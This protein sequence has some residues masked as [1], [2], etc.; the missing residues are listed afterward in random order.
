MKISDVLIDALEY[1]KK[2][3]GQ[4]FV[5][6]FGG[7]VLSNKT[8]MDTV[9]QDL[10]LLSYVGIHP[11]VLHGGGSEIDS[12]MKKFGKIPKK[13]SGLRVTDKETMDI[14]EMV[15]VGKMNTT[16]VSYIN[17]HGGNAV[18]LSGKSGNLFVA[19]KKKSKI[20][21]GHVGTIKKVNIDLITSLINKNHIPVISPVGIDNNGES[22][23]INADT[24][25]SELAS[26]LKATKLIILTDVQGVME[27]NGRLIKELSANDAGKL[28]SKKIATG[29]MIPKLE[30]CINAIS[31]GVEKAHIIKAEQHAILEEIFTATGNGTMILK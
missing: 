14:V 27:K 9:A 26:A 16:I 1:I 21:L 8:V 17:K 28:I 30:S 3:S 13:V 5:I 23:N 25:A 19:E 11:V 15:L 2:F 7:E 29:G 22:F 24:A 31:N 18:G 10:I 20:D 12:A 4:T 6:K